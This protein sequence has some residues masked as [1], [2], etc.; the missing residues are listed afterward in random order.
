MLSSLELTC[1]KLP[2]SSPGVTAGHDVMCT[3]SMRGTPSCNFDHS[4]CSWTSGAG[5]GAVWTSGGNDLPGPVS[6]DW[7]HPESSR[8][9]SYVYAD[10]SHSS[11]SQGTSTMLLAQVS[12]DVES[13]CM[14]FHYATSGTA[15]HNIRL[16]VFDHLSVTYSDE[17]VP[18]YE[19]KNVNT[20]GEWQTAVISSQCLPN[21]SVIAFQVDNVSKEST[22]ALDYFKIT[23]S[24]KTCSSVKD[25]VPTGNTDSL[26]HTTVDQKEQKTLLKDKQTTNTQADGQ[27]SNDMRGTPSCNF[28]HSMCS[29]QSA[30]GAGASWEMGGAHVLGPEPHDWQPQPYSKRGSY[31]FAAAKKDGVVSSSNFL[32]AQISRDVSCVCLE[33]HYATSGPSAH[34]ISV[35]AFGHVYDFDHVPSTYIDTM[36]PI[37]ELNNVNTGGEWKPALVSSTCLQDH[38]AIAFLVDNVSDQSTVALDYVK[39]TRCSKDCSHSNNSPSP[40]STSKLSLKENNLHLVSHPT[41]IAENFTKRLTINCTSNATSSSS[42]PGSLHSMVLSKYSPQDQQFVNLYTQSESSS[43]RQLHPGVTAQ[44]AGVVGQT[45]DSFISLTWSYPS[46]QVQGVYKCDM[47]HLENDAMKLVATRSANIGHASVDMDMV[48]LKLREFDEVMTQTLDSCKDDV[49]AVSARLDVSSS[50]IARFQDR[51]LQASGDVTTLRTYTQGCFKH[52]R[53]P[54]P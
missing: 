19:V 24:T 7:Q 51:L 26:S 32:M 41:S 20:G 6:H 8:R 39:M 42:A 4:T 27:C 10:P 15:L 43:T 50:Q 49:T 46:S 22:V 21:N 29:W 30:T 17:S 36:T 18:F 9:G 2:P 31:V 52:A 40:P 16:Y 47:F 23:R 35:Y 45:G 34:N 3:S 54:C 38:S 11:S 37:F 33:F 1:Y 25:F 13:V 28:D 14:E 53:I 48:L 12:H 5:S 44:A